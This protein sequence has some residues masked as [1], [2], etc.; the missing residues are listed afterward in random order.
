MELNKLPTWVLESWSSHSHLYLV[1]G[2]FIQAQKINLLSA[3]LPPHGC[4]NIIHASNKQTKYQFN[5]GLHRRGLSLNLQP[6][7]KLSGKHENKKGG[8]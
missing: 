3:H 7:Q 8:I 5:P 4:V 2:T 1:I 6:S